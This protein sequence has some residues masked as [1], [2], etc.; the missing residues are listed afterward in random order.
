MIDSE[1]VAALTEAARS[2]D[3]LVASDYDGT[4]TPIIDDPSQAF[5]H[6]P[7]MAAL[8]QLAALPNVEVVLISGRPLS[9]LRTLSGGPPGI[10]LVGSHGSETEESEPNPDLLADVEAITRSLHEVAERFA[11]TVVEGK[12]AG[13]T[14]HYRNAI[15]PDGAAQAAREARAS[16]EIRLIE[17]KQ[18][19]ELMVGP[20]D[21]GTALSQLRQQFS[22]GSLVFFGDDTTDE[23]VFVIMAAGDVGVKVGDGP[24]AAGYRV[25]DPEA[26]AEALEI[27]LQ[28]R[29]TTT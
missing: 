14:L 28:A 23:D 11:G 2:P 7:A 12:P 5:P 24:T 25:T 1:L 26:V 18:V 20:G 4:L 3:L 29:R 13:A 21:K 10:A 22:T 19:V 9:V 8:E 27:L 15:D 16:D 17:G 6:R